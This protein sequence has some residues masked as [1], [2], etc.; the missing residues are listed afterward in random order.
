MDPQD[1]KNSETPEQVEYNL[2][3][4]KIGWIAELIRQADIQYLQGKVNKAFESWNCIYGQISNRIEEEEDK[5]CK[6]IERNCRISL[7]KSNSNSER[8]FYYSRYKR[9]LQI[10]LKKYGFDMRIKESEEH[11]V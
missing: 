8:A 2:S 5:R 4:F 6:N 9:F 7:N 1:Y 10:L 3:A 11:L